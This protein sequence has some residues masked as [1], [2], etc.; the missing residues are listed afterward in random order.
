MLTTTVEP[1]NQDTL[2]YG[3]LDIGQF[4]PSQI[5]HLCTFQTLKSGHF[6]GPQGVRIRGVP[7]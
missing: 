1:L 5:L 4:L 2:K 6:L 3:Y 7:L